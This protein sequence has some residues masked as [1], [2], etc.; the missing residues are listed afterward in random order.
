MFLKSYA[1]LYYFNRYYL[2]SLYLRHSYNYRIISSKSSF[3]IELSALKSGMHRLF[4]GYS[5]K[6]KNLLSK[7]TTLLRSLPKSPKSLTNSSILLSDS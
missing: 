3:F 5:Q 2:T 4:S 1:K 6:L 7:Y